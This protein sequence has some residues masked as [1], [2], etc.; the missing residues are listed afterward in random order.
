[1]QGLEYVEGVTRVGAGGNRGAGSGTGEGEGE[2]RGLRRGR[3]GGLH[4]GEQCKVGMLLGRSIDRGT[5]LCIC[6]ELRS[7][8]RCSERFFSHGGLGI[9]VE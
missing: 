2:R 7:K 4:Q 3:G 9:R 6:E 1:M 5:H 8:I